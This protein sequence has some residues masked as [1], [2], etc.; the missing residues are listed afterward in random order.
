MNVHTAVIPHTK[1][2]PSPSTIEPLSH[3]SIWTNALEIAKEKLHK[4][5][6]PP[7]NPHINLG[8]AK[9][10]ISSIIEALKDV[11]GDDKKKRWVGERF[12]KILKCVEKYS[13]VVD[14]AIQA[15]PQV[16]ALVW[17]G[18]WG[19]IRVRTYGT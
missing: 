16:A 2:T 5:E 14:I 11:Q 13:K 9:E 17:A 12:G 1:P 4:N 8:S 7:L 18:I 10:N 19:M 3:S 15:N 6:L